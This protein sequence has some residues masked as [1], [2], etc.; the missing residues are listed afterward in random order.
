MLRFVNNLRS[1]SRQEEQNVRPLTPPEILKAEHACLQIVQHQ[2]IVGDPKFKMLQ[3]SL[4]VFY[5]ENKI[6]PCKGGISN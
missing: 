4:G 2:F 3:K 1:R 6:L 5:D